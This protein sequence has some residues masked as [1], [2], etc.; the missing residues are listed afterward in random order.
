MI[1]LL[2][3]GQYRGKCTSTVD[4]GITFVFV[5]PRQIGQIRNPFSFTLTLFPPPSMVEQAGLEPVHRN[6]SVNGLAIRCSTCYAYC[7]VLEPQAG[8]EPAPLWLQIIC[9]ACCATAAFSCELY[10]QWHLFKTH[11]ACFPAPPPLTASQYDAT[12]AI[13]NDENRPYIVYII[14]NNIYINLGCSISK[15]YSTI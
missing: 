11:Q 2:H 3:Q 6:P 8:I 4:P 10:F 1:S 9:T 13:S 12:F 5:F 14:Y 7:S 15:T